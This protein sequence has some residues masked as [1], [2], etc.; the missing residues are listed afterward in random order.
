VTL[1]V[2]FP[3]GGSTDVAARLLAE[4]MAS[5]LGQPVVVENRP[6][7]ATVIGAEYV[8]RRRMATSS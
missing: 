7:A 3:P 5:I 8:A 2:S 6:G 1:V 4:R